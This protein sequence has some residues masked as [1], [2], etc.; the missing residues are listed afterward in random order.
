MNSE[1]QQAVVGAAALGD[2]RDRQPGD[3]RLHRHRAPTSGSRDR[4]QRV[5]RRAPGKMPASRH[6][7]ASAPIA[8]SE[9]RSTSRAALGR[10]AA[11]R[12][13]GRRRRRRA[14]NRR[15]RARPPARRIAP[16]AGAS[17][18]SVH[19]GKL[20]A[21]QHRL[22]HQPFRDEAVERRQ[23]RDRRRSRRE[24]EE[25]V[26]GMRLSRP[27]SRSMSRS[28]VAVSTAPAPKNSR[29][30]NS[31]WLSDVQQ[32][33]RH[34]QRRRAAMPFA[35]NAS[36]RPRPMKMRPMFSIVE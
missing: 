32:R 33:R 10:R 21:E 19:C 23:R 27:P 16:T 4:R 6:S 34:R 15:R 14:R 31:A 3:R 28:P 11:R 35:L 9:K 2:R 7:A 18:F 22:Q 1:H 29:L 13:R 12:G 8:A 36:A 30:L 20:R 17:S 25:P 26:A 5:D 24:R